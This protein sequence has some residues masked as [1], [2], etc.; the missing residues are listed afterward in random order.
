MGL[1]Y[2]AC[3][4]AKAKYPDRITYIIDADGRIDYA[5]KVT[6]IEAHIHAAI[7]HLNDA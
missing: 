6:D 4:D 2:R 3:A 5:E 1:A 7:A